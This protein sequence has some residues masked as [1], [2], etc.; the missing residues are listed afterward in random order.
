MYCSMLQ[1]SYLSEGCTCVVAD[2]E[3]LYI[4]AQSQ[5]CVSTKSPPGIPNAER[6]P[7]QVPCGVQ[8][9]RQYFG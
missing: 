8:P 6:I 9:E 4:S 2:A 5:L 3:V 1:L 7:E